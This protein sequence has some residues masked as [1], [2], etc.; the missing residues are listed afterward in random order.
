MKRAIFALGA[1][2]LACS[3]AICSPQ[4]APMPPDMS[5]RAAAVRQQLPN[6]KGAPFSGEFL[7]ESKGTLRDGT[8]I[9]L[10]RPMIQYRDSEGRTR[11]EFE[12][13][14]VIFDPVAGVNYNLNT[15]NMTGT[16]GPRIMSTDFEALQQAQRLVDDQKRAAAAANGGPY[17]TFGTQATTES[18]GRKEMH[19]LTVEG[20]QTTMMVRFGGTETEDAPI[21]KVVQERWYSPELQID[22]MFTSDDPRQSTVMVT[23]YT[24]IQRGEP[25]PS[26]FRPPTGYNL[27]E[28]GR[29]KEELQ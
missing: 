15:K 7:I 8:V 28:L 13:N 6:I 19:G 22:V 16:K 25:D 12:G 4:E 10:K 2:L 20:T 3:A 27:T 18:L 9:D 17:V 26:L 21:I 23:R 14:I 5:A 24:N 29:K 11:R 1:S